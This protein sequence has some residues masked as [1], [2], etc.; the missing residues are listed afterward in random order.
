[1]GIGCIRAKGVFRQTS[2]EPP[3]RLA[4]SSYEFDLVVE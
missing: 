2:V 4:T 1:M 3:A